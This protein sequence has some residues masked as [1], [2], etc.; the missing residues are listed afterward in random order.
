MNKNPIDIFSKILEKLNLHLQSSKSLCKDLL[1]SSSKLN[2]K[3]FEKVIQDIDEIQLTKNILISYMKAVY[4]RKRLPISSFDQIKYKKLSNEEILSILDGPKQKINQKLEEIF[5]IHNYIEKDF[6]ELSES[7][8]SQLLD[9]SPKEQKK[10][11]LENNR[12]EQHLPIYSI[13]YDVIDFANAQNKK[14]K[15][16]FLVVIGEAGSGKSTQIVQYLLESNLVNLSKDQNKRIVI[17]QPRKIAVESVSKRV[18][19]ELGVELGTLIGYHHSMVNKTSKETIVDFT[20][21]HKLFAE[22]L[23]DKALRKYSCIVIDEAHERST[24]TD[25]I[26]ALLKKM[27]VNERPDLKIIIT[28][29]TLNEKLFTNFFYDCSS[30]VV[31]GRAYPVTLIYSKDEIG[32]YKTKVIECIQECLKCSE[33]KVAKF[34]GNMLAFL[35]SIDDLFIIERDIKSHFNETQKFEIVKLY[36]KATPEDMAKVFENSPKNKKRIILSTNIAEASVTVNGVSIVIDSGL[37]NE[38]I[39]NAQSKLSSIC[40]VECAQSSCR[41]RAGRAGRICEG[42]CFRLYSEENMN[43]REKFKKPEIL[44]TN[45]SLATLKLLD[46]DND[47]LNFDFIEPPELD[48]MLDSL[49]TLVLLGGVKYRR[50]NTHRITSIGKKMV[51]FQLDPMLSKLIIEALESPYLKELA[52]ITAMINSSSGGLFTHVKDVKEQSK[53]N[54]N[55]MKFSFEEGDILSYLKIY[56]EYKKISDDEEENY[57]EEWCRINSISFKTMKTAVS[58]L[59]EINFIVHSMLENPL[60]WKKGELALKNFDEKLYNDENFK[61][62]ILK[63][64]TKGLYLNF[65]V[66]I[67][68]QRENMG[69]ILLRSKENVVIHPSSVLSSLSK[70]PEYIIVYQVHTTIRT[71][72][73]H[74]CETKK[75]G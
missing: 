66:K 73:S 51:K 26:I 48:T 15:D 45:V 49:N 13:K 23:E 29:A 44:R 55:K 40:L 70:T 16:N 65:G 33:K 38:N 8:L 39:C 6:L 18:S 27:V 10:L 24:E 41:Q 60:L 21:D 7:F 31:P 75:N 17:T 59:K 63:G 32:D 58:M 56:N 69:Y 50:N 43:K 25:I 74:I 67:D 34:N 9:L 57:E 1:N 2:T 5:K 11:K 72:A 61:K 20:T 3:N 53:H 52:I 35:P 36:S 71:F 68:S 37:E 54:I 14:E 4:I 22:I 28:S 64:I 19:E 12:L 42:V 30:L 47:P 46:L 62:N